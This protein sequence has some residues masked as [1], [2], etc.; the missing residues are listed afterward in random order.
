MQVMVMSLLHLK[1]VVGLV[2]MNTVR[3]QMKQFVSNARLDASVSS[4]VLSARLNEKSKVSR[5][6]SFPRSRGKAGMG[7]V[8]ERPSSSSGHHTFTS[9][10]IVIRRTSK[11]DPIPAFD[12]RKS[13]GTPEPQGK[14]QIGEKYQRP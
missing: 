9:V 6:N 2:G 4:E 8:A 3:V 12:H 10:Q 7:D 5:S 11:I 1:N 14:E 13:R